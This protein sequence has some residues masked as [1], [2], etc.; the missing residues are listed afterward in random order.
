MPD[1][2]MSDP[3]GQAI[4]S[5]VIKEHLKTGEPVG[6][7]TISDR[8]AHASGWSAATIRNV[9][10]ELEE[11][12]LVEQPH[13]S[14]GR[15]PTDKGY[16]F[17][18][19]HMLGETRLSETDMAAINRFL[20]V[21]TGEKTASAPDRLMEKTSHLLSALSENVGIVVSPS[22]ADNV[23]HHIEF[24]H[25]ADNRILVVLVSASNIVHN[26]IIRIDESLSQAELERTARYLNVEFAGKSLLA[27][28]A[29][30]LE[31]MREEKALY[32]KLLR[33]AMLLC[34]LSLEGEEATT[35]E[36]YVD[37]AS[38]ILTKPDFNDAQRM[39]ELFRTFEEKSRLVK[40]LNECV[41]RD[42]PFAGDVQVVI[43][44]EHIAPSMQACTLITA[45]YRIGLGAATGA[46]GVVGPMR[47]EYERVVAVVNY[48]ARLIERMLREDA[49]S[50]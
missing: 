15:V 5:A 44:R 26:K 7:R 27:I 11:A 17:Y 14:A 10:G 31:L 41:T 42:Q 24:M 13:T 12:G 36:V 46:L 3:R 20:G 21:R 48:V 38:N 35:G 39:R 47:I 8:F 32:D 22:L 30:I 28:R 9:M 33:N 37:G 6:S 25:L 4:L 1:A 19:D 18:V 23:L 29:E 43:G 34:D 45:P 40:I 50:N 49:A 2:L 16:R